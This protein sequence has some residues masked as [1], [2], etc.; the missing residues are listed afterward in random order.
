MRLRVILPAQ[1]PFSRGNR[2]P[3]AGSSQPRPRPG[4][5]R[6]RVG[7]HGNRPRSSL[8]GVHR[9]WRGSID[10]PLQLRL[11]CLEGTGQRWQDPSGRSRPRSRRRPRAPSPE[12]PPEVKKHATT[13]MIPTGRSMGCAGIP[14]GSNGGLALREAS[15]RSAQWAPEASK[16]QDP[17]DHRDRQASPLAPQQDGSMSLPQRRPRSGGGGGRHF[18]YFRPDRVL[19]MVGATRAAPTRI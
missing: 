5:A 9:G 10:E 13:I 1:R 14:F 6:P 11:G 2:A 16:S 18:G 8:R 4:T 19:R 7:R 3:P 15:R 17:A 12:R